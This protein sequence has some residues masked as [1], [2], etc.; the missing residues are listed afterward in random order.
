MGIKGGIFPAWNKKDCTFCGLCEAVCPVH[1]VAV[2]KKAEELAFDEK[3]C[4][5]CGKCVK[6][7][8]TGAW[9]GKN[10]YILS[11]GGMF[12]N[13]IQKGLKLLPILF[14]KAQVF[15]VADVVIEFYQKNGKPS[16]RFGRT[17]SRV[18]ITALKKQLE[19]LL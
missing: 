11:F 3:R 14:D 7:C 9:Q 17:L 8:P 18:G 19:E 2:N 4:V 5:Y 12:G 13:E 10:G 6:S 16:E 1:V 15:K